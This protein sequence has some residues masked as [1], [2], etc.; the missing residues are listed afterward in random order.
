MWEIAVLFML[1]PSV[2]IQV[3]RSNKQISSEYMHVSPLISNY[4]CIIAFCRDNS[5]V[6][7]C[8]DLSHKVSGSEMRLTPVCQG[9]EMQGYMRGIAYLHIAKATLN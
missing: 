2:D 3:E 7:M 5:N 8:P 6:G 1:P 9:L 4:P